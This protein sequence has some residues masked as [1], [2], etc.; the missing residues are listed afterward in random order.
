MKSIS[1]FLLILTACHCDSNNI[2]LTLPNCIDSI[3][4]NP[5]FSGELQT[6]KAQSVAGKLHY[7][8]NTNSTQWDGAEYIVD[9]NCDTV[10]SFC[11]ECFLPECTKVYRGKWQIIW[12]K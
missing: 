11:G 2:D 6:I 5:K 4:R 9:M 1:L 8:L 12:K 10:C 7:W 3:V